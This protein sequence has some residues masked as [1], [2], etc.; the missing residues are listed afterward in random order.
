MSANSPGAF[1]T[2]SELSPS[3]HYK[4]K[5]LAFMYIIKDIVKNCAL[6]KKHKR[7]SKNVFYWA[8]NNDQR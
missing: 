2:V 5:K 1:P 7:Q 3:P 8:A 4:L 6:I